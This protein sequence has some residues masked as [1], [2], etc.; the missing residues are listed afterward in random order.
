MTGGL[1]MF[2]LHEKSRGSSYV[3][4]ALLEHLA[5]LHKKGTIFLTPRRPD[6]PAPSRAAEPKSARPETPTPAPEP[7]TR[8]EHNALPMK[9]FF[10]LTALGLV[11]S[12]STGLLMAWKYTRNRVTVAAVFLAGVAIPM[13]LL[14]V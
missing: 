7:S 13:F 10:G 11:V 12:T 14:M 4:P 8:P 6:P 5:Q 3:P 9:V 2:G 1:Q